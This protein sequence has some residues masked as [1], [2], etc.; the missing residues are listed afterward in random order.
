MFSFS[1][2]VSFVQVTKHGLRS[3]YKLFFVLSSI[4]LQ[5]SGQLW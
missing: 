5:L 1:F 3:S 4:C 2:F